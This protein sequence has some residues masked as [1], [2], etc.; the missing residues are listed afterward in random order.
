MSAGK[1]LRQILEQPGVLVLPGV[2]DCIGA[3]IVEQIGFPVVFTSGFGIS[4]ST[5]GRPDYGFIT[6]T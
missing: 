3:K 2:Y 1:K 5:L 4:G 6:A